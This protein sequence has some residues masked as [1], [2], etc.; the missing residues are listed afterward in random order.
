M[1]WVFFYSLGG[2]GGGGVVLL[3][4]GGGGGGGGCIIMG[5]G[6]GGVVLLWGRGGH[7]WF[8]GEASPA[9]TPLDYNPWKGSPSLNFFSSLLYSSC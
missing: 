2:G 9:H 6:G 4:G 1:F 7:C 8:G 3:W 5:G